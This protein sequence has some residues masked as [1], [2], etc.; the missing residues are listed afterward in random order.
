M[1]I[2]KAQIQALILKLLENHKT[3]NL[4]EIAEAQGLEIENAAARRAIQR[5]LSE[6]IEEEKIEAQGKARA[7]VYVSKLKSPK[8]LMQEPKEAAYRAVPLSKEAN[9]L[10]AYL[11]KPLNERKVVSYDQ[12]FLRSYQPNHSVYLSTKAREELASM[13]RVENTIRPAGTYARNILN[14]LLIDLSWNSSRLEGNT[15]SLLETKRLIEFGEDARGK[16]AAET[17]MIINHK[18]AIEYIVESVEEDKI[19]FHEIC[20]IHALLSENLLGDPSAS[21]R[22][23]EIAVGI[24][25]TTYLPIENSQVLKNC[26]EIFINK[27]NAISDPYEQS[28]FA[29]VHLSYLQAFEDV[30]KRTARLAANIP[31]IKNNLKPLSFIDVDQEI[32]FAALLGIYEKHDVSLLRDLYLWAY[33]RSAQRYSAVQQTMAEPN[34]M[35]LKYRAEIQEIIHHII[36][37]NMQGSQVVFVIRKALNA[38]DLSEED[39]SSL[40]EIIETEI[41]SLHEGNI[42]RFKIRPSEYAK[43]KAKN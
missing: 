22:I 25:G 36:L 23:R 38:L 39:F 10:L 31:F 7:R 19:S 29:M 43:W 17:Q 1:T 30:N 32:Y 15:Y 4:H 20:S 27:L 18:A 3:I 26:F 5:A 9:R 41:M 24:S 13:G 21:G 2:Q 16:D 28:F 12:D 33:K 37:N 35:K 40:L 6:L 11:A 14:R 42:A 8:V 34:L